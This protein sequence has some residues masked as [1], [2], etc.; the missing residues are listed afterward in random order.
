MEERLLAAGLDIP[1]ATPVATQPISQDFPAPAPILLLPPRRPGCTRAHRL[2]AGEAPTLRRA[3]VGRDCV[4]KK[5]FK[6]MWF[7]TG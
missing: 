6:F 7:A 1:Q 3:A 2:P 4:I 5:F